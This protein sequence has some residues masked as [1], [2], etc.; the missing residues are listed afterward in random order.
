MLHLT[1]RGFMRQMAAFAFAG[2][3][4]AV[5]FG[6]TPA[7]ADDGWHHGWHR[8]WWHHHHW[9]PWY[10]HGYYYPPPVYYPPPA[11]YLPPAY[12]PAPGV[13]FGFSFR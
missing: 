11:Y 2:A 4:V 12:Y 9:H 13:T 7:R 1:L 8:H 5:A 6:G 10:R 3:L